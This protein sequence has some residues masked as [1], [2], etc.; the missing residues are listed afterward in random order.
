M[1]YFNSLLITSFFG[2]IIFIILYF[3]VKEKIFND[4]ICLVL[5][6]LFTIATL[7]LFKKLQFP[8]VKSFDNFGCSFL[9]VMIYFRIFNLLDTFFFGSRIEEWPDTVPLDDFQFL[10][11]KA[12][13]ISVVGILLLI[14]S[15]GIFFRLRNYPDDLDG[16]KPKVKI[17]LTLYFLALLTQILTIPLNIDLGPFTQFTQVLNTLGI[18]SIFYF[19]RGKSFKLGIISLFYSFFMALPFGILALKSGL[20]EAMFFPFIPF[21]ILSWRHFNS[22]FWRLN[23]VVFSFIVLAFSQIYITYIRYESWLNE[24]SL[25]FNEIFVNTISSAD[26]EIFYNSF[27]TICSRFNLTVPHAVTVS[28][29]ENSGFLPNEILGVIPASFVPRLFWPDKPILRPGSDHTKRIKGEISD[30]EKVESAAAPG[31]FTELYLAGGIL[32]VIV[33]SSIYGLMI[34]KIQFFI[35]AYNYSF[36]NLLNFY[37]IYSVFRFDELAIAYAYTGLLFLFFSLLIIIYISN[38]RVKY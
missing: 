26:S 1:K 35:S 5:I 9:S 31:F 28:I 16:V 29:S 7:S 14:F 36:N 13:S 17:Y 4:Q 38:L 21:V 3:L 20:K 32:V 11:L 30:D 12:E 37:L 18:A 27:K 10:V 22:L 6:H 8:T 34:S 2:F 15:W 25:T 19:S 24:R 33:F 23:I